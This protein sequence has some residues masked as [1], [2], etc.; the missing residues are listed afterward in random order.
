M[1]AID[2][3]NK[4]GNSIW[5]S[6]FK[7]CVIRNPY[8]KLISGFYHLDEQSKNQKTYTNQIIRE[9]KSILGMAPSIDRIEGG[10]SIEKFRN[11]IRK[12]GSIIDRDK[13]MINGTICIDYFIRYEDLENGVMHVCDQLD[14]PF[15]PDR[16]PKMK[17]GMRENISPRD[18]YDEEIIQIVGRLYEFELEYFGYSAPK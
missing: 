16:I 7:F 15:E 5:D 6:Y 2:I 18:Y 17:A 1:S 4:I 3:R 10:D 13:Y 11:W 12:G 8:D 9:L 14:I